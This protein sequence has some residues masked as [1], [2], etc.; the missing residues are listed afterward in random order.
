MLAG[1][2]VTHR[3]IPIDDEEP[4]PEQPV[5]APVEVRR[6]YGRDDAQRAWDR[7]RADLQNIAGIDDVLAGDV[8]AKEL[9]QRTAAVLSA[10]NTHEPE[11]RKP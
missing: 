2:F 10:E 7:R 9:E 3:R 6:V 8:R 5:P 4:E 1:D 11:Q